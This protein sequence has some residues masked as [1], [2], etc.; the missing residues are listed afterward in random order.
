MSKNAKREYDRAAKERTSLKERQ[1][2]VNRQWGK[3]KNWFECIIDYMPAKSSFMRNYSARQEWLMPLNA[4]RLHYPSF[5]F[6]VNT[7]FS[8]LLRCTYIVLINQ[9]ITLWCIKL[10][11]TT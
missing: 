2:R 3:T 6:Q 10:R 1:G 4:L 5:S 11:S 7:E 8:V 9:Q